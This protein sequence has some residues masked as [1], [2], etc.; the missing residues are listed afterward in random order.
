[1]HRCFQGR[2][3]TPLQFSCFGFSWGASVCCLSL[4]GALVGLFV[5]VL[6]CVSNVI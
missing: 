4:G 5:L 1:M 2:V 3:G 6:K